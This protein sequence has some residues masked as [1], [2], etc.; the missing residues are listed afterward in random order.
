[1]RLELHEPVKILRKLPVGWESSRT[2][3]T[4]TMSTVDVV[5]L[6]KVESTLLARTQAAADFFVYHVKLVSGEV[7]KRD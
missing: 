5:P 3:V 6:G 7:E 2:A 1:M 4:W